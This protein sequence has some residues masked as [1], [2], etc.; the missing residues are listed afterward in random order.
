MAFSLLFGVFS[1]DSFQGI[2][3]FLLEF[4][5]KVMTREKKSAIMEI[6]KERQ[7]YGKLSDVRKYKNGKKRKTARET[8]LPVP[9][10]R[11]SIHDV[12]IREENGGAE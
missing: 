5:T 11:A 10:V 12:K 2:I 1:P 7:K 3:G 4:G 8:M 6:A 9:R